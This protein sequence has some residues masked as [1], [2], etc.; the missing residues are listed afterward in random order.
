MNILIVDDEELMV[1]ALTR[2]LKFE[3]CQVYT[4]HA[5]DQAKL[6]MAGQFI[7][8]IITDMDLG[9]G[10]QHGRSLLQWASEH[11]PMTRRVL[12]SGSIYDT[13]SAPE[14]EFVLQ[15][16][17]PISALKNFISVAA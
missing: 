7:D 5:M 4:A 8:V 15:K 11:S 10:V 17:F 1:R 16:P 13:S 12:M 9:E 2:H 3:P 6:L 14:A